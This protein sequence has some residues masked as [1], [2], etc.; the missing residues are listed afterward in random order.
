M[1]LSL[2]ALD[3]PTPHSRPAYQ[4][5]C[6]FTKARQSRLESIETNETAP[7][8]GIR[9]AVA[10]LYHCARPLPVRDKRPRKARRL[11][12]SEPVGITL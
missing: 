6:A 12:L 7:P 9:V 10:S 4:F 11:P 5:W 1:P 8:R 2:L 3:G